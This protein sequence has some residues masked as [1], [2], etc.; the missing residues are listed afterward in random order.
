MT[1]HDSMKVRA[2]TDPEGLRRMTAGE[3][4]DTF[5]IAKNGVPVDTTTWLQLIDVARKV[6]LN[7]T[8]IP[9]TGRT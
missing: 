2:S 5:V 3:I 4:R 9:H 6:R 1:T 7:D 8:E